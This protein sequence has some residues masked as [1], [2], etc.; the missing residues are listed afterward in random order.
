[1]SDVWSQPF[2]KTRFQSTSQYAATF[3]DGEWTITHM[4][5]DDVGH[6]MVGVTTRRNP[7]GDVEHRSQS[8]RQHSP[9][10]PPPRKDN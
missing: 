9:Q 8:N 5:T 4:Q 3:N 1:M 2:H 7:V 6:T 10:L